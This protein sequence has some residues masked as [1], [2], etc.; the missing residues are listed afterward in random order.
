MSLY[1]VLYAAQE[2]RFLD[3]ARI[4]TS[5]FSDRTSEIADVRGR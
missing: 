5:E 4:Y 1:V 3:N 2:R